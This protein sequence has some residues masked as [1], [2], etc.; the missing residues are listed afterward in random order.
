MNRPD[1]QLQRRPPFT[2]RPCPVR[3]LAFSLRRREQ[4]FRATA[5][6]NAFSF[7]LSLAAREGHAGVREPSLKGAIDMLL[8]YFVVEAI[9]RQIEEE[10][11]DRDHRRS[12]GV[13]R[14]IVR[15]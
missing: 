15:K 6:P 4:Q 9:A 3:P 1:R 8:Q 7:V 2:F 14:R 10:M 5:K 13:R 11:K 12:A